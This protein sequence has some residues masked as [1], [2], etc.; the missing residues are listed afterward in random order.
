[1]IFFYLL[2]AIHLP[3]WIFFSKMDSFNIPVGSGRPVCIAI[4]N[5]IKIIF[6]DYAFSALTL[7]VSRQE[8]HP[9]CKN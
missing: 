6:A 9:A 7:L 2:D 3:S 8:E 4:P 1:M 5:F